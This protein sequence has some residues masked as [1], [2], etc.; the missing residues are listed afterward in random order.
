MSRY[1]ITKI[2][3][4]TSLP[5]TT[6]AK[7][8]LKDSSPINEASLFNSLHN[9]H[10]DYF[11]GGAGENNL[12]ISLMQGSS[13]N[14][15]PSNLST[16]IN[17]STNNINVH[18]HVSESIARS[19]QD[20]QLLLG[21]PQSINNCTSDEQATTTNWSSSKQDQSYESCYNVH[22][23]NMEE[24]EEKKDCHNTTSS[25]KTFQ[26][27]HVQ[28]HDL[29]MHNLLSSLDQHPS[30]TQHQ[31]AFEFSSKLPIHVS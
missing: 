21:Y 12:L 30:S 31:T 10:H 6:L 28:V 22:Q 19:A 1:D 16:S 9:D 20:W 14:N 13:F 27:P 2:C 8:M 18:N 15:N 7:R 5:I 17:A 29:Q 25:L 11:N 4:S 23:N 26:D 24:S 3:S